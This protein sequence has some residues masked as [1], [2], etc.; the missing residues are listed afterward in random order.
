MSR[1]PNRRLPLLAVGLFSLLLIGLC[2][3]A[4]H[5]QPISTAAAADQPLLAANGP[6][7]AD[8][9]LGYNGSSNCQRC[10]R[11]PV[12]E[13]RESGRTY[14]VRMDESSTWSLQDRHSKAFKLLTCTRGQSMSAKLGY[15]VTKDQRCLSCHADWQ[16]KREIP[17]NALMLSEGVACEACHGPSSK[18][19]ADHSIAQKWHPISLN[20]RSTRYG[21]VNVRD[22]QVRADVCLSCHVGNAEQGKV[23]THDMYAA[24]HPP[25]PSFELRDF[26]E[27]MPHHWDDLQVELRKLQTDHHPNA[28]EV[29]KYLGQ[30]QRQL[31]AVKT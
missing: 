14:Y 23:V 22:P 26:C 21:L 31:G 8:E 11:E 5:N 2:L 12:D 7:A 9:K 30:I 13:D 19:Y 27:M 24:G 4:P 6:A 29:R 17:P 20:D 3:L 25:L 16:T 1:H 15:D 10:H 18:Y 28:A